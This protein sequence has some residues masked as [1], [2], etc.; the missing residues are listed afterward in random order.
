MR[1]REAMDRHNLDFTVSTE[2]CMT[3]WGE[4]V[5]NSKLVVLRKG[6]LHPQVVGTVG[7]R[8][9]PIQPIEQLGWLDEFTATTGA[10]LASLGRDASRIWARIELPG[11]Y[12]VSGSDMAVGDILGQELWVTDCLDGKESQRFVIRNKRL[13]CSNGMT[14]LSDLLS[15]F[16]RHVGDTS[17]KIEEAI[18]LVKRSIHV[19]KEDVEEMSRWSQQIIGRATAR[20]AFIKVLRNSTWTEAATDYAR[21]CANPDER[22]PRGM[23]QL[24]HALTHAPG[25]QLNVWGLVN[26]FTYVS[27]HHARHEA[28][29]STS[30]YR[31]KERRVVSVARD[32]YEH[33]IDELI[34]MEG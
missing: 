25:A 12:E 29:W 27:T 11:R 32:L 13:A 28:Q 1:V 6:D 4:R 16:T 17:G 24:D 5:E 8:W 20:T 18:E 22:V 30:S 26:A 10:R 33:S 3:A 7:R 14:A 34:E 2:P 21:L 19:A 31:N 15:V 23:H 9:Q